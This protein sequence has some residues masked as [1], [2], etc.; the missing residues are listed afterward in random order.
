MF[1]LRLVTASTDGR[2]LILEA[3]DGAQY[4]LLIDDRLR[5]AVFPARES[6]VGDDSNMRAR[7]K[8]IQ[9]ML[10]AGA[11]A[12]DVARDMGIPVARVRRF[13]SPVL[14]ERAFIAERARATLLAP[15]R[16]TLGDA[17]AEQMDF[18]G[19]PETDVEWDAW[20]RREGVWEVRLSYTCA[21][22]A[23][24]ASW[25]FDPPRHAVQPLDEAA[26]TLSQRVSDGT[27]I[28]STAVP[29]SRD[30]GSS[31]PPPPLHTPPPAQTPWAV[32]ALPTAQGPTSLGVPP[33]PRRPTPPDTAQQVPHA[34]DQSPVPRP[35]YTDIVLGGLDPRRSGPTDA[36]A[37]ADGIP[38]GR[39]ATVPHWDEILFGVQVINR[40]P[41]SG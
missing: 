35:R 32:P 17:V 39:R 2:Q 14:A 28:P 8:M 33:R 3:A 40:R 9:T 12:E 24:Q 4:T 22:Q 36:Q 25:L 18:R 26:R 41:A 30:S 5:S 19:V 13:E 23:Y 31:V 15:G 29:R 37:E 7:P 21:A 6:P 27:E 38:P 1:E 34:K 11:S 20:R 10:R 16:H